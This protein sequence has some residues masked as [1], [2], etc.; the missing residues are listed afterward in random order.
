MVRKLKYKSVYTAPNAEEQ[1]LDKYYRE[2]SEYT[3]PK[4]CINEYGHVNVDA[5]LRRGPRVTFVEEYDRPPYFSNGVPR[6]Y[7]AAPFHKNHYTYKKGHVKTFLSV[8]WINDRLYMFTN[9]Y[10]ERW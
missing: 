9:F 3:L 10:D 7:N 8:W 4:R 5:G 1:S 2:V 6:T